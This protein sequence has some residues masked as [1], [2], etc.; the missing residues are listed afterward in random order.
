VKGFQALSQD[1]DALSD[2]NRVLREYIIKLQ[3]SLDGSNIDKPQE[4]EGLHSGL[5]SRSDHHR[6]L[7]QPLRDPDDG[8]DEGMSPSYILQQAAAAAENANAASGERG[9]SSEGADDDSKF[10]YIR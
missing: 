7:V 2:E 6:Q 10:A 4:P 8:E 3:Q 9:G 1:F 5:L